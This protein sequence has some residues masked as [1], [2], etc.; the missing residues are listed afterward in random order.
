M[1]VL[2]KKLSKKANQLKVKRYRLVLRL[3]NES[4]SELIHSLASICRSTDGAQY[5]ANL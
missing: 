1:Q 2:R 5:F 3:Y 4:P